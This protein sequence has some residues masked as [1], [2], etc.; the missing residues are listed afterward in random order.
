VGVGG[1]YALSGASELIQKLPIERW[2][3]KPRDTSHDREDLRRIVDEMP[4]ADRPSRAR[5]DSPDG[6]EETER[7]ELLPRRRPKVRLQRTSIQGPSLE[8]TV[9]YQNMEIG[10]GLFQM[11]KHFAQKLK[12]FNKPCDCGMKTIGLGLLGDLEET[13]PLVEDPD[14]YHRLIEWV[15][16]V[17]PKSTQEASASGLYDE[18]YP[19]L[20]RQAR[21][22]R[23]EIMGTLD[24]KAL[25]PPKP[26][27]AA[28]STS[29]TEV[30]P[31][32]KEAERQTILR[33]AHQKIDQALNT[34]SE[35]A[36]S[37][38]PPP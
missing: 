18:E 23:K 15:N 1:C 9:A 25:F 22:F 37:G 3:I 19:Q 34:E 13:I 36:S 26:A 14:F 16:E 38:P 4:T 11:E 28:G 27:P 24:V 32:L 30:R 21:D 10:K 8:E 2:L 35:P 5:E 29:G 6:E 7:P 31:V 33:L 20:S 17:L 12:I